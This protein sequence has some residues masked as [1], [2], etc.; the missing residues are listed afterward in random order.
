MS[1][2]SGRSLAAAGGGAA[3]DAGGGAAPER[4]DAVDRQLEVWARE[5][6]GLDLLTEGV[7]ERISKLGRYLERSMNETLA[8]FGLSY[9]EFRVLA[10]L[11]RGGPPYRLSPG[12]LAD[13]L[14]LSSS[15]MTNRLDRLE[16]A[17][18]VRRLPDPVDRRGLK[19]EP[20]EDGWRIWEEIIAAQAE[21]ENHVASALTDDEKR[22]L[23]DL[24]RV[25]MLSFEAAEGPPPSGLFHEH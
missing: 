21:K 7:V 19:I 4:L 2:K 15:A 22:R 1:R 9:G 11:R 24:L 16:S 23:S 10:L 18:V 3:G 5:L 8:Q 14:G 20:T 25:L 17:H 6:P 12:Y 13:A